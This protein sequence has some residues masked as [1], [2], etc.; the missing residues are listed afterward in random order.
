MKYLYLSIKNVSQN[1]WSSITLGLFIFIAT[2]L[3][4][5]FNSF[6]FSIKGTVDQ[7]LIDT[8]LGEVQIR[9][10][11]VESTDMIAMDADWSVNEYLTAQ[12][13][14]QIEEVA[15]KTDGIQNYA[16]RVRGTAKVSSIKNSNSDKSVATML[17]GLDGNATNYS[18]NLKLVGGSYL[19]NNDK[20]PQII[21]SENIARQLDVKV[22][23]MIAL[24]S[25][26]IKNQVITLRV[27]VVGVGDI[28]KVSGYGNALC[29]TDISTMRSLRGFQKGESS[30]IIV[31][32][33][34]SKKIKKIS[35]TLQERLNTNH[36]FTISTWENQGG[37]VKMVNM[38]YTGIFY[39]CMAILLIIIAILIVNLVTMIGIERRQEIATL[40]AIGF[41]K[42]KIIAIFMSEILVV[43]I[44]FSII[45]VILATVIGIVVSSKTFA[46]T[47]FLSSIIGDNFKLSFDLFKALP[48]IFGI[49]IFTTIAAYYPSFKASSINPA[50]ILGEK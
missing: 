29:Y 43:T 27:K 22:G 39:V 25:K 15:S 23:D 18:E 42:F 14:K 19:S 20:T 35:N 32:T 49:L 7:A 10:D 8:L 4:I 13:T 9:P 24:Q 45:G 17:I 16:N 46:I 26:N 37:Y 48:G 36:Q 21:L 6:V 30:E 11:K 50:D 1:I 34:D 41:S 5:L 40:R 38:A 44:L 28:Q 12:E 47:G 33:T 3:F 31:Y 2:F